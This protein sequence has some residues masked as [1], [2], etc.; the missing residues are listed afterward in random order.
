[1]STDPAR[2]RELTVSLVVLTTGNRPDELQIALDSALAQSGVHWAELVVVFNGSALTPLRPQITA[3]ALPENVGIPEGRNVGATRTTGD[4]IVFLDD[5]AR[6][7]GSQSLARAIS[8][9]SENPRV[10]AISFRLVDE[11]GT[12]ARRHVPRLG[13]RRPL[14]GG[15]VTAF[16]G[17]AVAVRRAAFEAAGGYPGEFFYSMEESDLSLGMIDAGWTIRYEP[18][19]EVFHPR[20]EPA[21]HT[22]H[23]RHAARNRVLLAR[24]RLPWVVGFAYV[25]NWI[26]VT[27]ARERLRGTVLRALAQGTRDGLRQRSDRSPIR[28]RTVWELTRLGRPPII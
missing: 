26:M 16:L 24:R 2:Q 1:M 5:D 21:R 28:W 12:T 3:V 9:F 23:I 14:E 7:T 22:D 6:F 27:L 4:V 18:A 17:G 25:A 13:A 8:A 15:E 10:G 11:N 19:V 20:S